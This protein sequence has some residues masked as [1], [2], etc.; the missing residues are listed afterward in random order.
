MLQS[1]SS[2]GDSDGGYV[3]KHRHGNRGPSSRSQ[4]LPGSTFMAQRIMRRD[5]RS[6]GKGVEWEVGAQ[7]VV[8]F[9]GNDGWASE[10]WER[11]SAHSL[12]LG[13]CQADSAQSLG[14]ALHFS[15]TT[16]VL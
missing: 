7:A 11:G 8:Q 15:E 1:M 5:L 3:S 10:G 4:R 9:V 6:L 14:W 13:A 2:I 12:H 16:S